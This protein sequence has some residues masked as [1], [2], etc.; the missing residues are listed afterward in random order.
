MENEFGSTAD[1]GRGKGTSATPSTAHRLANHYII[2]N[3]PHDV[4]N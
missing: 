1:T 4:K 3:V 2:I